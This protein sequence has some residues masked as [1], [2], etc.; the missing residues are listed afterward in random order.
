MS[1]LK[2]DCLLKYNKHTK[3][4]STLYMKCKVNM[5]QGEL[6]KHTYCYQI[7]IKQN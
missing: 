2:I 7:E 6:W 4:L 1:I 3:K 5:L